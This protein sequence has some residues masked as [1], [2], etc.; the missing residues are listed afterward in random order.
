MHG[1]VVPSITV[2]AYVYIFIFIPCVYAACDVAFA[3]SYRLACEVSSCS[4][5]FI[6]TLDR[7]SCMPTLDEPAATTSKSFA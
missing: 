4:P 2:H 3:E 5:G 7:T 1:Y 6:P